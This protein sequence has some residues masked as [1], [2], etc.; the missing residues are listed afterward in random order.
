LL[1]IE[2]YI[3]L[4][5]N[6]FSRVFFFEHCLELLMQKVK[7]R[8]QVHLNCTVSD[9]KL[10]QISKAVGAAEEQIYW[11]LSASSIEVTQFILDFYALNSKKINVLAL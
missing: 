3:L 1:V 11:R 5:M 4:E 10:L 2:L 7:V 8:F 9:V 6:A